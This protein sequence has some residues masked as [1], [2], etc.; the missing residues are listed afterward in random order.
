LAANCDTDNDASA[1]AKAVS[2]QFSPTLAMRVTPQK[3]YPSMACL[4]QVVIEPIY[5]AIAALFTATASGRAATA[6][7][8]WLE[9]VGPFTIVVES[10]TVSAK[11]KLAATLMAPKTYALPDVGLV[12]RGVEPLA[13]YERPL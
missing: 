6:V 8:Q 1:V 3:E 12:R 10:L 9:V 13:A 7:Q 2:T 5:P 11:R 4:R